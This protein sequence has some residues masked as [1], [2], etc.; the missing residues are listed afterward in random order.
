MNGYEIIKANVNFTNPDRIG[1]RFDRIASKGDVYRIFV[2]PPKNKRDPSKSYSVSKKVRPAN[3]EY[4]EWGCL[5]ES[6]DDSGADMGQVTNIP[7]SDWEMFDQYEFPDPKAE[8]RFDGLEKALAIAEEKGLYVQLNS[9]QC[10]FERMH[11]LRGF[12]DTLVDSMID[13]EY[14][15]RLAGKL[16][17]YQIGIIEEAHRLGKGRIHCYDTTDDWGTQQGLMLSPDI[18]RK[19]FKPHYKRV[20]D[21]AKECGMDVRLHTDGKVNDIVEDFIEIGVNILNIHQPRLVGI[22][23]ISR[24]AQGRICF[25]AAIDIQATLPTGD[26]ALIEQEAKELIEKWATPQGGFI[27]VEYGYLDAIGTTKESMLYALECFE[28]YGT[29]RP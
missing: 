21:K 16:A 12:E 9:P 6:N 2:L 29:Y 26:K 24:I 19:L 23:E 20:F 3:G 27:G 7:L 4:D 22:D 15:D 14:I 13:P 25:E 18:F 5:W 10:I 28:K 11:F 17:D 1:L 8:G